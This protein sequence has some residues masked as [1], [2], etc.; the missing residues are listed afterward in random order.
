MDNMTILY[1]FQA[2]HNVIKEPSNT[3]RLILTY[4]MPCHS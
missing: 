1:V 4:Q 3:L 2:L